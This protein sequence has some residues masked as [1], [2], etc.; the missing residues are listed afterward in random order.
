MPVKTSRRWTTA[1]LLAAGLWGAFAAEAWLAGA[2]APDGTAREASSSAGPTAFVCPMHPDYTL[3]V[4]GS[5]PRCGMALVK[6]TPFDVRN[7]RVELTT[8]PAVRACGPAGAM[9]LSRVPAR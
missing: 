6:A 4:P 8:T 5:C 1:L 7:Y 9:D 3:E 2:Q